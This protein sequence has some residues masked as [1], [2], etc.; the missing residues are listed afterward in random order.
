MAMNDKQMRAAEARRR[1]VALLRANQHMELLEQLE[2]RGAPKAARRELLATI[3]RDIEAAEGREPEG[4]DMHRAIVKRGLAIPGRA[5]ARGGNPAGG[6]LSGYAARFG[7]RSVDLGGFEE[8]IAPGA[9]AG[10]LAG[11]ADI[12][13]LWDHDSGHVIGS[14]AAGTLRLWED[15]HGLAFEVDAGADRQWA[16]DAVRTVGRGDVRGASFGFYV[17]HDDWIDGPR[18]VRVLREV[19]LFE[20]S[21][22]AFPAYPTAWVSAGPAARGAGGGGDWRAAAAARQREVERLGMS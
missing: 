5:A 20:I 22:V 15:R 4:G 18:L 7:E 3:T 8:E 13:M 14:T 9:F 16:A 19:D 11:G 21:A 10:T 17:R 2:K 12:K 6:V 1:E